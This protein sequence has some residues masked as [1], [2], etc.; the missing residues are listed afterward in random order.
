MVRNADV[1]CAIA[2]IALTTENLGLLAEQQNG[3]NTN[4]FNVMFM[5]MVSFVLM[6]YNCS[7]CYKIHPSDKCDVLF[8]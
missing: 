4:L 1:D 8:F 2:E 5:R 7:E 6:L 3:R